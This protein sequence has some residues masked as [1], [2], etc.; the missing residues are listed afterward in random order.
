PVNAKAAA[1]HH[2]G[3][4]KT[5]VVPGDTFSYTLHVGQVGAA[6]L[7]NTKLALQ[8]PAG[9]TAKSI[10]DGGVDEGGGNIVWDVGTVAVA[11]HAKRSVEVTVGADFPVATVREA[12]SEL[13]YD[14]GAEVD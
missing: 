11:A 13:R 14:G 4:S 3:A 8:L 10:S 1:E 6:S 5:P 9:L 12:R 2:L 7:Q